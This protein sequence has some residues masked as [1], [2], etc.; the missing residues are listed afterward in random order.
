MLLTSTYDNERKSWNWKKYASQY[1]KY[2]V[3]FKNC[4]KYGY[5]GFDPSAKVHHLLNAAVSTVMV[6]PDMYE[7]D[8]KTVVTFYMQYIEKQLPTTSVKVVSIS[9][10]RLV[11]QQKTSASMDFSKERLS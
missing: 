11:K 6:H 5:Q 3:I 2:H 7:N 10:N 4:K 1:V 9:C 8:F